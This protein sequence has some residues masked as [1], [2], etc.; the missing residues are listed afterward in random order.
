[1]ECQKA[2]S[3][4]KYD[5]K[6]NYPGAMADYQNFVKSHRW[7]SLKII[8]MNWI[9]LIQFGWNHGYYA[10][11]PR[12]GMNAFFVQKIKNVYIRNKLV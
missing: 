12:L 1:M 5:Y 6:K 4:P 3:I 9:V 8:E 2:V 10:F 11:V 7:K